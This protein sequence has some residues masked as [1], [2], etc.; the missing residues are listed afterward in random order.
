MFVRFRETHLV[1]LDFFS[2][3]ILCSS[4]GFYSLYK[5]NL[6]LTADYRSGNYLLIVYSKVNKCVVCTNR[7]VGS[8]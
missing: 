7:Y 3:A 5:D 2:N 4:E 1:G 8:V 6:G